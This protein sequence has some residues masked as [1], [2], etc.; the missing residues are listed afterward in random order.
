[1]ELRSGKGSILALKCLQL[2]LV[3]IFFVG[4]FQARQPWQGRTAPAF[5]LGL[6]L[7]P[8]TDDSSPDIDP[9]WTIGVV[10]RI[11]I[12]TTFPAKMLNASVPAVTGF[13]VFCGITSQQVKCTALNPGGHSECGSGEFLAICAM[14]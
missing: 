12:R 9:V 5:E 3:S 6:E 14:A 10:G 11:E 2:Y 4:V 13:Y 1:M 8:L 7:R